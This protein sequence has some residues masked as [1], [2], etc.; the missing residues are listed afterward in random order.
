[1]TAAAAVPVAFEPKLN[2]AAKFVEGPVVFAMKAN[3]EEVVFLV[4]AEVFTAWKLKG[5]EAKLVVLTACDEVVA[6]E[7]EAATN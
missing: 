2:D 7:V 5:E 6:L 1:M 3:G 4:G